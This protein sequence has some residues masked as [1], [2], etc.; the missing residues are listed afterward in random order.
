MKKCFTSGLKFAKDIIFR[1]GDWNNLIL[2][3]FDQ[4]N[5]S[6][7]CWME[8]T[9]FKKKPD[10]LQIEY[11][12]LMFA[13]SMLLFNVSVWQLNFFAEEKSSNKICL[14]LVEINSN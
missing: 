9:E 5:T 8:I 2:H 10:L 14:M 7:G 3:I 11:V 1:Y 13:I 12:C 4:Y 6:D